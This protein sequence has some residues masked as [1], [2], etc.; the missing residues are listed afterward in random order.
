[1]GLQLAWT[2]VDLLKAPG[3]KNRAKRKRKRKQQEFLQKSCPQ[4][5]ARPMLFAA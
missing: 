1:M 3:Q 5:V 4:L 2:A